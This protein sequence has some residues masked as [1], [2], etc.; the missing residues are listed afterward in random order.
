LATSEVRGPAQPRNT[1]TSVI[2]GESRG[3]VKCSDDPI[4]IPS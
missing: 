2:D 1:R 3:T 4:V